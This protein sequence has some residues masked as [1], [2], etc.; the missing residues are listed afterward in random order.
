MIVDSAWSQ[1][2]S[3]RYVYFILVRYPDRLIEEMRRLSKGAKVFVY[4]SRFD[5]NNLILNVTEVNGVEAVLTS[6]DI[7]Y[8]K[9]NRFAPFISYYIMK[10]PKSSQGTLTRAFAPVRVCRSS[11]QARLK[12][13]GNEKLFVDYL[14]GSDIEVKAILKGHDEIG[15]VVQTRVEF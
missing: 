3:G 7:T 13:S 6:A 8:K 1:D 12:V 2:S 5:G 15:R 14:L 9:V 10:V 4:V 11:S